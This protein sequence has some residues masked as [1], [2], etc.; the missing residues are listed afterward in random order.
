MKNIFY[1]ITIIL[2]V[3]CSH[4][5]TSRNNLSA[6]GFYTSHSE[7]IKMLEKKELG[8]HE[9]FMLGIAYKKAGNFKKSILHFS[10]SCF[11]YKRNLNLRLYPY[12]VYKHLDSF[13]FK[14][15]YYNNAVYEIASLFYEYRE[16]KYTVKFIDLLDDDEPA[17]FRD[18][19]ILKARALI[20]IKEYSQALEIL[21][22]FIQ[23]Y[24]DV[25]SKSLIHI[26]I[27]SAY[28]RM[29]NCCEA[30][31][32]YFKVIA[33]N[34]KSWHSDVAAGRILVTINDC[35]SKISKSDYLSLSRT[36]YYNSRYSEAITILQE[37]LQDSIEQDQKTE[38]IK[39]LLK[40][41]IR[42][43][44]KNQADLLVQEYKGDSEQ[45]YIFLEVMADE[46]WDM[47]WKSAAVNLYR[48]LLGRTKE[49]ASQKALRKVAIFME[50]RKIS[51]FTRYLNEYKTRYPKDKTSEYFLWL[52]A[53]E[54]LRKSN[55]DEAVKFL[56][57]ALLRHAHGAYSGR[58]RFWLYKIYKKYNKTKHVNRILKELITENPDSSYT[59]TVLERIKRIYNI[60]DLKK[61]FISSIKA[62]RYKDALFYHSLLFFRDRDFDSR[63]NRIKLIKFPLIDRYNRFEKDIIDYET[64]SDLSEIVKNVEKYFVVGYSEGINR[65]FS[66]ISDDPKSQKEI[67]TALSFFGGKYNNYYMSFK[68]TLKMLKYYKLKENMF[69]LSSNSIMRLLPEAF[70][71]YIEKISREKNISRE[72]IYAM[73]KSESSFNHKAVSP[74]GATGLMQLMPETAKG[75]AKDLKISSYDLKNPL[76]SITFGTRYLQ[77]LKRIF[78]GGYTKSFE[79]IVGGYNAGA[80]NV[81]KWRKKL[82]YNDIDY[83][84]EFIPFKETKGYILRTKKYLIQYKL[85][86]NYL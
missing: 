59:W 78:P 2:T 85:I 16:Y 12:P 55:P 77:W 26:R 69:I 17:L 21:K 33:L 13:N 68:G 19:V 72:L 4:N 11:E 48:K 83:Y 27:A 63:D 23:K 20:E 76:I 49:S 34:E 29:D 38:V 43:K 61:G 18:A 1:I 24:K 15:V 82:R 81:I 51:G 7:I 79:K 47:R 42:I 28:E 14:S 25:N 65:E 74:A 52:L 57:E 8:Y 86:Y 46:L 84:I 44:K 36:L 39:Y 67:Y 64:N 9:H 10:N 40:S 31:R 50:D 60:K 71:N 53:K 45:Y 5:T 32:E 35:T 66:L 80:G 62:E 22:D 75:V 30:V 70:K 41:Y 6:L 73:I 56:E 54:S 58:V 3:A 37:L